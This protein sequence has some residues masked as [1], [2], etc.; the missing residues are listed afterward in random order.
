V[1]LARDGYRVNVSV[2]TLMCR[3]VNDLT[4]RSVFGES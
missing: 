1:L 3:S 4:C 2:N